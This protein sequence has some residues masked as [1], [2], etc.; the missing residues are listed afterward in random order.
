VTGGGPPAWGLGKVLTTPP[1]RKLN[2]Y[3]SYTEIPNY[4]KGDK[5]IVVIIKTYHFCQLHT[6]LHQT[7]FCQG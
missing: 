1:S 4:K 7:S 6:K 5:K 2:M 3:E